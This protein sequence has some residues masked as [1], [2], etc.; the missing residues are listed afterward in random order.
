ME[1][2]WNYHLWDL[3][4]HFQEVERP[5]LDRAYAGNIVASVQYEQEEEVSISQGL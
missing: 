1:C 5:C 3:G 2:A 4:S